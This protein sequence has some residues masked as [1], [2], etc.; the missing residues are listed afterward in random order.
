MQQEPPFT[1]G[2]P[3]WIQEDMDMDPEWEED[4]DKEQDNDLQEDNMA[5]DN[6]K[7]NKLTQTNMPTQSM[8]IIQQWLETAMEQGTHSTTPYL[9]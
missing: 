2:L 6:N 9:L 7:I 1:K 3:N 8:T 5:T 4:E